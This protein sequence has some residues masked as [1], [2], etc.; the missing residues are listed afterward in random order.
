DGHRGFSVGLIETCGVST[1]LVKA[2]KLLK[3]V[4][5]AHETAEERF[6]YFPLMADDNGVD[7]SRHP[8]S[9]HNEM[10]EMMEELH[11]T[12]M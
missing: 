7:L 10:D 3:D 8:I 1:E 5:Q 2:N 9:E 12:E 4:L 11:A 6:F